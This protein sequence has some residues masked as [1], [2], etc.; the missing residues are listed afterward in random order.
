MRLVTLSKVGFTYR[1][2]SLL[3]D[4][5]LAIDSGQ[6]IGLLGRNGAGKSTLMKIIAGEIQPD[7]GELRRGPKLKVARLIQEVPASSGLSIYEMVSNGL[8]SSPSEEAFHDVEHWKEE[9]A[10]HKTLSRMELDGEASFDSLSAG[11]KRRVLLAQAIVGEP[12]LLLLDEPTNHLDIESILWLEG[13]LKGFSGSLLFVTHDRYFLQSLATRILEVDRGRIFDWECDYPTFL[14]RKEDSLN[15]QEKQEALFDKRLAAEEVWIR[16]GVKA[17]RTRNEGRVRALESMRLDRAAR[18]NQQ[19]NA[20]INVVEAEKSGQLVM[21]IEDVSF[22]YGNRKII[23]NFSATIMRGD[24]IGIVGPNGAGK[25]TLLKLLLGRIT[26]DSGKMKMGTKVELLYFDQLREQIDGEKSVAFNVADGEEKL[27]I[28]GKQKHIFSYLQDFL[29]T[30]DRSRD[31]AKFLSGGERNRLLLAR[32]FRH[33]SN[34]LVLDEPTNDLD[35]ETLE[36]LEELVA[37]YKGTLLLVSHD[38]AFLNNVVT[39]IFA[40]DGSGEVKEYGGGYDDYQRAK[41]AEDKISDSKESV[42]PISSGSSSISNSSNSSATIAKPAVKLSFKEKKDLDDMPKKIQL[43]ETEQ[44][45]IHEA[46]ADPGFFKQPVP[47]RTEATSRLA[48]IEQQLAKI[49][50]RWEELEAKQNGGG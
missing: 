19:G 21:D 6:R 47:K 11:M 37:A 14:K 50:S 8:R 33:S 25:S 24:K 41:A 22:C 42:L 12:D 4:I 5:D 46:M 48:T 30:P 35:A 44:A 9:A 27:L 43:L 32:L 15:A 31:L 39:T 49:Y 13:F 10:I 40:V 38:R 29:F 3:E 20:R 28:D 36:L 7:H 2:P 1:K 45:T 18:R 26:P 16:Q 34:L 17:R 23:N